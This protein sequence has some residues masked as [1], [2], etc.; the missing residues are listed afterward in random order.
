MDLK[1]LVVYNDKIISLK[2]LAELTGVNVSTIRARFKR[3]L[4]GE[5]LYKSKKNT[6]K[7]KETKIVE[8]ISNKFSIP[9]DL[10]KCKYDSGV[11]MPELGLIKT[12]QDDPKLMKYRGRMRTIREIAVSSDT[13]YEEVKRRVAE[14]KRGV[15]L[16]V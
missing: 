16:G 5:N 4:R 3:G 7:S 1:V 13:P 11:R 15:L 6:N 10:V 9:R 2:Q 12:N 8:C 14:G